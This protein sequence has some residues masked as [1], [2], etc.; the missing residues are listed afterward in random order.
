MRK[1]CV[2]KILPVMDAN[3]VPI[4]TGYKVD[5]DQV[6]DQIDNQDWLDGHYDGYSGSDKRAGKPSRAYDEGYESGAKLRRIG[7]NHQYD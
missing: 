2:A 4:Q 5:M 3:I 1:S 6:Y 7:L